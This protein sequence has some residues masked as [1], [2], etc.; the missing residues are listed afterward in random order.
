MSSHPTAPSIPTALKQASFEALRARL[1]LSPGARKIA[2]SLT[3][4]D[5]VINHSYPNPE[6]P[7]VTV[8]FMPTPQCP[9]VD[10]EIYPNGNFSA[11]LQEG[12]G[13]RDLPG[14]RS[15]PDISNRFLAICAAFQRAHTF[16]TEWGLRPQN[17]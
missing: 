3:Q 14:H 17:R 12:L 10:I 16:V 9:V 6:M 11:V 13:W 4:H 1:A 8:R 15:G 2:L 5:D 7:F